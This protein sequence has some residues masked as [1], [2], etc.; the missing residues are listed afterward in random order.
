MMG[1]F[2]VDTLKIDGSFVRDVTT[3]V[4]S[5]SVVAAIAEVA[6][7][8]QLETV[9]EFV[10]DQASLDLLRRLNISYAQGFFVGT[11]ELLADRI[12]SLDDTI[13]RATRDA[14]AVR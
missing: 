1:L 8:M 6:R 9:A 2:P 3:N 10:Q 12:A 4:V 14:P 11:T 13:R 5:Q 7:V